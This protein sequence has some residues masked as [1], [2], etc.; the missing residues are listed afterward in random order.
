MR[1]TVDSSMFTMKSRTCNPVTEGHV[2]KLTV[3][4][5]SELW[6]VRGYRL[7]TAGQLSHG[8]DIGKDRRKM[9]SGQ[10][11]R[12]ESTHRTEEEQLSWD[13]ELINNIV[14]ALEIHFREFRCLK[15][16]SK[17]SK[18]VHPCKCVNFLFK[19]KSNFCHCNWKLEIWRHCNGH[20]LTIFWPLHQT[21]NQLIYR[22]MYRWFSN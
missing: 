3:R 14:C 13:N 9:T 5:H 2:N 21:K 7:P 22:L 15:W 4:F 17:N 20:F 1:V 18:N 16:K 10:N 11:A 6:T 12:K 8:Q 19:K